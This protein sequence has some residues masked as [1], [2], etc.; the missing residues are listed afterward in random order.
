MSSIQFHRVFKWLLPCAHLI[1]SLVNLL[2]KLLFSHFRI[3]HRREQDT[4]I[5]LNTG[6]QIG[7]AGLTGNGILSQGFLPDYWKTRL[8]RTADRNLYRPSEPHPVGT[9]TRASFR[10]GGKGHSSGIRA[11]K[12]IG[13]GAPAKQV[14]NVSHVD[15]ANDFLRDLLPYVTRSSYYRHCSYTN[16]AIC[17]S[18]LVYAWWDHI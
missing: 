1:P 16:L 3:A 2:L 6:R 5:L 13:L 15:L 7:H 14:V 8:E 18:T 17:T 12:T 9:G 4:T 11:K 10:P